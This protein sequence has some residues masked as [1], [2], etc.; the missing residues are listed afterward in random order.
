MSED[1]FLS[2]WSRR[3]LASRAQPERAGVDATPAKAA[4]PAP[5]PAP[6]AAA[7]AP[8][9]LPA[10]ESLTP[11]SDFAPFMRS[12]V[13]PDLRQRALRTLFRDPGFDVV[14][15][16]NVYID[17]YSKP[18]PMP[19]DWLEKLQQVG[20]LGDHRSAQGDSQPGMAVPPA[21]PAPEMPQEEQQVAGADSAPASDTS[22]AASAPTRLRES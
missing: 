13:E 14:D 8:P 7:E 1:G 17:D 4:D 11:E 16:M 20:R 5:A 6:T 12:E 3:K 2:R 19:A 9:P 18:D 22:A 10:V 21:G 15:A